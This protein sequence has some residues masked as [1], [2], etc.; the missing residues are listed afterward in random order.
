MS[1]DVA[2]CLVSIECPGW[3]ELG[4]V[5]Q[6]LYTL[7]GVFTW[8]FL[9]EFSAAHISRFDCNAVFH[10]VLA[11]CSTSSLRVNSQGMYIEQSESLVLLTQTM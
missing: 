6:W 8:N 3:P 4:L 9:G 11:G 7:H 1:R 5:V 2:Q 10:T